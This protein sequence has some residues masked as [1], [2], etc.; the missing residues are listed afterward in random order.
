M[1][2]NQ[3]ISVC[4]HFNIDGELVSFNV[5]TD[6][7]IN[8]TYGAFF[9]KDGVVS[10]YLVQ[11]VNT[12]VFKNPDELMQNIVNVTHHLRKKIKENGGNPERETLKFL[13]GKDGKYCHYFADKCWRIYK[14]VDNSF[15]CSKI[16][17]PKMFE[18]AGR[19]FGL[20]QR[21]LDGYPIDTL[22]ETIKDFHNTPKRLQDLVDSFKADPV[23]RASSVKSEFDFSVER[24]KDT[25][26]LLDCHKNGEI[27]LRV[28]H[29]DTKLNNILFDKDTKEAICVID[30]DTIM[31]GFSLYDFG[32]A[33]RFGC[34]TTKEDDDNL[35]NVS[36]SLELFES[37]AKGFLSA[38]AKELTPTEV[39]YLAFSAK[40]MTYECA[41]RFLKDYIDGD[42]YFRINPEIP[43][44]NLI[45]ARNQFKLVEDIESK[46]DIMNGIVERLYNQYI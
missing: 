36:F 7:H 43:T 26:I 31:P 19:C 32:D 39:K 28:T 34:N 46:L 42:I 21:N 18:N 17:N 23:G 3:V 6:G 10:K 29:N 40:L 2:Q 8:S 38:C 1:I 14:F 5:F 22:F 33:L 4:E 15:A 27:P 16:E 37:F 25:H 45:R 13:K 30:L 11:V 44:H 41:I 20:F 24:E 35:D 12:V 9:E